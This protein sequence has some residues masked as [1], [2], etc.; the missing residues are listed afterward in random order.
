[1]KAMMILFLFDPMGHYLDKVAVP[2]PTVLSC[3][4]AKVNEPEEL[5]MKRVCVTM[6]HWTGKSKDKGMP[7]EFDYD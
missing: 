3:Q 6:D 7:L 5:N 1:M 2:Y 4:V